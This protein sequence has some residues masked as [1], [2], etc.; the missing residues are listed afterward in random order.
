MAEQFSNAQPIY[1]Q[2]VQR[3]CRQ[4][5][6]REVQPGDKL[7]S[8]RDLAVQFGVNPNTI[9]RVNME[10]ERMGIVESRRGQGMFVTEDTKQL[11]IIRDQ[12]RDEHITRFTNEMRE[13]GY[14]EEEI[15]SGVQNFLR[16]EKGQ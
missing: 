6:R 16:N 9:Q 8:V 4:I 10:L 5:V 7:P 3:I 14:T 2:L 11:N 12:L 1:L 15:I 13:L